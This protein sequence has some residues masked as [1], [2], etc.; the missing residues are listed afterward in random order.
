[1]EISR[2]RMNLVKHVV[3]R[4]SKRGW[5]VINLRGLDLENVTEIRL[6]LDAVDQLGTQQADASRLFDSLASRL[7]GEGEEESGC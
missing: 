2:D 3:G 5:L 4:E 6:D 1:M 7:G